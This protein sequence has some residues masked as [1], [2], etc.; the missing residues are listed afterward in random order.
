VPPAHASSTKADV[1]AKYEAA[2]SKADECRVYQEDPYKVI[3]RLRLAASALLKSDYE[4]AGEALDEILFDL[5][6]FE[7]RRPAEFRSEVSLEWLEIYREV[8]LKY[9]FIAL[10]GYFFVKGPLFR[11]LFKDSAL[12]VPGGL[13]LPVLAVMVSIFASLFDLTQYGESAWAFFDIQVVVLAIGG[14]LGGVWT[15]L[16]A[17]LLAGL[18]RWVMKP[19]F[20]GYFLIALSAGVLGGFF[21]RRVSGLRDGVGKKFLAGAVI[22]LGHGILVYA[23]VVRMISWVYFIVTVLFLAVLEG[24]GVYIFFAVISGLLAEESKRETERE[25]LRTR[26]SFLQAQMSPHFLF[27]ALNTI[28]AICQRCGRENGGQAQNLILKLAHFLR[29]TLTRADEKIS[30]KEEM[31]YIDSYLEIERARFQERL[32]VKKEFHL[33]EEA[34]STPVP[35]L[36]LQPLVENAVKHGLGKME[37]GGT[38][39]ILA[40]QESEALEVEI[41]DNGAGMKEDWQK[42][43]EKKTGS[44]EGNGSE[45]GAGIGIRNIQQ[46]LIHL[47]GADHGLQYES[48]PGKGTKVTVRIPLKGKKG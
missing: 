28:A 3:P 12:S 16:I 32:G 36:I 42:Y 37:A 2:V 10:L 38:L 14:L 31:E 48:S 39:S 41:S 35:I 27:N 5:K 46:R 1:L 25:L 18:F 43:L 8:F 23:P 13:I 30:F 7:T 24:A 44:A 40:R 4:A 26:L 15:G 17:G 29:R 21:S 47:Y 33:S 45:E 19:D 11:Y 20:A 9:A 22:G 6:L 34:W